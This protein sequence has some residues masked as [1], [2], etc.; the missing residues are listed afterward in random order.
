M[1]IYLCTTTRKN[2]FDLQDGL[3]RKRKI[4]H[5]DRYVC[6]SEHMLCNP[7][8]TYMILHVSVLEIIW[9]GFGIFHSCIEA[10][11]N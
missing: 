6:F 10:I 11:L 4:T 8:S 5:S 2:P 9:F 1:F 7:R 3:I